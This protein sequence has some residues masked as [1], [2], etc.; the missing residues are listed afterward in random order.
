[1]WE[2]ALEK[3][4]FELTPKVSTWISKDKSLVLRRDL[5]CVQME[6]NIGANKIG[7]LDTGRYFFDFYQ[8]IILY[9]LHVYYI[10]ILKQCKLNG[11]VCDHVTISSQLL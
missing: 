2:K 3:E 5:Q 8:K 6:N 1:M 7:R 4:R 9:I 11:S 10:P